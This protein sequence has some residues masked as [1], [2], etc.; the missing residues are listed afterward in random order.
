LPRRSE[1]FMPQ[2]LM[3]Q[4]YPQR[5]PAASRTTLASLR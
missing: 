5:T 1:G 2:F 3:R 4:V